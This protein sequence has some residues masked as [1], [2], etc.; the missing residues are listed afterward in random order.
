MQRRIAIAVLVALAAI[1]GTGVARAA[2]IAKATL[3]DGA[4]IQLTDEMLPECNNLNFHG[5]A[6]IV[7]A[8]RV[9]PACWAF[10]WK[11][12]VF[13]VIPLVPR[14]TVQGVVASVMQGI[15]S[16]PDAGLRE[17]TVRYQADAAH[18]ISLPGTKFQWL[19]GSRVP[20]S[21]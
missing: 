20:K 10:D 1:A 15:G 9:Q 16:G 3:K 17:L 2:N 18:R 4:V 6:R 12:R 14:S 21:P 8:K 19:S 5:A 7:R 11:K 13:T